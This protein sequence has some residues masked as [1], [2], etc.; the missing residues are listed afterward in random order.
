[1]P[2]ILMTYDLVGGI[3]PSRHI[4]ETTRLLGEVVNYGRACEPV[5][6]AM[7]S[8]SVLVADGPGSTPTRPA[9][10]L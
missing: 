4:T 10:A 2:R 5:D 9:S 1:V 8:R 3:T 7:I 6:L